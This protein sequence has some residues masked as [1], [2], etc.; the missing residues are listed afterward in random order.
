MEVKLL[1]NGPNRGLKTGQSRDCQTRGFY[2]GFSPPFKS[3][4]CFKPSIYQVLS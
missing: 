4:C 2:L 1:H 3:G